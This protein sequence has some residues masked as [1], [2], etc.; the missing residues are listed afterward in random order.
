MAK[1]YRWKIEILNP[2]GT[3]KETEMF[4]TMSEMK[5]KYPYLSN[6]WTINNLIKKNYKLKA[7]KVGKERCDFYKSIRI[8]KI[9]D[10]D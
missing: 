5:A 6:R 7:N 4:N 8:T 1:L 10:E 3:V 2:D 9:I